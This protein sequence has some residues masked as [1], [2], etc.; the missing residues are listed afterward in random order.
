MKKLVIIGASGHGKVVADI[1]E[2]SGYDEII[3]LDDNE[4]V[5]TCGGYPVVGQ[6]SKAVSLNCDVIVAIGNATIRQ[7]IQENLEDTGVK[8]AT[9]V[10]PNAVIADSVEI[11]IGTVVAAGAVLNP[12]TKVGKSCIINTCSSV[13]HDCEIGDYV[14]VSVGAHVAGTARIGERTWIG[15]GA[16]V[17]NNVSI[18][19]DCIIGVG[20]A[21]VKNIE[22][23]GTYVGVPAR[24]LK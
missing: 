15:A 2:K 19:G 20:A 4:F 23:K 5:K 6:S 16:T 11:G 14:H 1:A 10:H 3:F 12:D 13:D 21:V 18:C 8:L 17:S 9:L 24:E 7:R 22:E